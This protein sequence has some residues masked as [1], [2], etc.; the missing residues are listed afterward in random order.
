[1]RMTKEI[2]N[3]VL[4]E[5]REQIIHLS[6]TFQLNTEDGLSKKRSKMKKNINAQMKQKTSTLIYR[7]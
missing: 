6:A 5:F 7:K 1:M 4:K 2:M 3:H